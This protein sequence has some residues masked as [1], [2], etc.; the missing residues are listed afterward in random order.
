M[1]SFDR[2]MVGVTLAGA[3]AISG[4]V[5]G[6]VYEHHYSPKAKADAAEHRLRQLEAEVKAEK[7]KPAA[8]GRC[9]CHSE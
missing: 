9:G 5:G 8:A 4:V 2:M 7:I 6:G 3:L 1:D